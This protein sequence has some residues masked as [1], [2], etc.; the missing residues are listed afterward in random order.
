MKLLRRSS[1]KF[2]VMTIQSGDGND[3]ARAAVQARAAAQDGAL[4]AG[5]EIA[6]SDRRPRHMSKCWPKGAGDQP[7]GEECCFFFKILFAM[8]GTVLRCQFQF[9]YRH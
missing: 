6:K 1:P 4:G 3:G 9:T 2:R 7:T 8:A 5:N